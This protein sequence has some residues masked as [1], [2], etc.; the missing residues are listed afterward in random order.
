[1][2]V[3]RQI[4][5]GRGA[6]ALATCR[7]PAYSH[8]VRVIA[9]LRWEDSL[10]ERLRQAGWYVADRDFGRMSAIGDFEDLEAARAAGVLDLPVGVPVLAGYGGFVVG[11]DD[12]GPPPGDL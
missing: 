6:P 7:I 2:C 9:N 4:C 1:M 12:L 5:C 10:A 11:Y 8:C 3:Q